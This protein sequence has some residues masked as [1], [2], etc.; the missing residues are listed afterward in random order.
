MR[1]RA[2]SPRRLP[3]ALVLPPG[4][5]AL[6]LSALALS[7]N[8]IQAGPYLQDAT[9]GSLWVCWETAANGANPTESRVDYGTSPLLGQTVHGTY[10]NSS[11]GTVIHQTLVSGLSPDTIY[12]Y[13][14][15]TGSWASGV[16]HFRTQPAHDAE[17]PWR[18]AAMSDT[19]VDGSNPQKHR[20]VIEDGVIDYV[21]SQ[22]GPDVPSE[23]SFLIN[24]GDLVSTGTNHS[25]WQDHFFAQAEQLLREVPLYPVLGN[26]EINADLYFEYMR[27][28]QNGTPG[29]LEHWYYTDHQNVRLIGL[30]TNAPYDNQTQLD[31][32]DAVLAGA[33]LDDRIDFVFVQFHHPHKSELWLPGESAFSGLIVERLEQFSTDTGKP[34]IHFFGHTHGYSRGQSRDHNHLWVNVATGMG[35]PDYWYEYS[36]ADYPEFQI[37]LPE[38]GFAVIDVTAGADPSFRLRR[39]S[40]GNEVVF[41]DNELVDEIT[42]RRYNQPPAQPTAISPNPASGSVPGFGVELVSSTFVDP[43]GDTLLE[44]HWQVTAVSGDYSDPLI[45]DWRR[46]ENWYRPPNGDGWYSVDIVVDPD[47]EDVVLAESLPG[48]Q[49]VWWRVRHRDSGLE[50]S[51]WSEEQTFTVGVSDGGDNIPD[52]ADGA[53]GVALAPVLEWFP[54][55]PADAYDVYFGSTPSLGSGDFQGS[56]A[57][58]TFSPGVLDPEATYYWRI[59]HVNGGQT[60]TG[61]TWSFTTTEVFPTPYTSEWRFADANPATGVPLEAA[62]GPSELVPEGMSY[63]SDWLLGTT[64]ASIPHI[65]GEQTGYL[66]LDEVFGW[67]TG[68]RTWFN[69]P[70]NGGGGGT[71][72]FEFTLIWDLFVPVSESAY[73]AL[74]QGN[75]NNANDAEFFLNNTSGGF[76]MSE[77]GDVGA[78]SWSRGE[79]VRIAHRVDYPDSSAVF[80][81]GVKVLSDDDTPA[82]DWL[83]GEGSGNSVWMLTDQNGGTDVGLVYCANL[84]LTDGLMPDAAIAAL[85]GPDA[86]GIFVPQVPE[87]Y[88]VAAPNSVGAGCRIGWTGS[89]SVGAGDFTLYAWGGI[90][91]QFG[92]FYYGSDQTQVPFG[93]GFR[94]VDGGSLGVFRLN[95]PATFDA[96]GDMTRSLDFTQPPVGSGP[97]S[98]EPGEDWNFQLWYR[99]PVGGGSGFNL[100]D[101]LSV[102]F[103]P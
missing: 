7:G 3:R 68:L 31:W 39:L 75:A 67:Q 58:T 90:P 78:G 29:F 81:N 91:G 66:R 40:R 100:S 22:Y 5:A 16:H 44:S 85:G 25:H 27:T 60:T 13:Q 82:P 72:V 84:A 94:C 86:E 38:W 53:T 43:D 64:G 2:S 4:A 61:P 19:Q 11:A 42:I 32:L 95:P 74:W 41:K 102:P 15:I 30:D 28:P 6:F 77:T 55:E 56:Q 48:C 50:W 88:C 98:I 47:I 33:A 49:P 89:T 37:S 14:V 63:G 45:D 54:C 17:T 9:P 36:Q 52:P 70:G 99:D 57:G 92:L 101:A 83:Y 1:S 23:L 93:E 26:H 69:A 46:I 96:F 51:E 35:N 76:W 34:S 79:W 73:Q 62:F 8:G 59:D 24:C 21:K 80:V 97:G 65:D 18:F 20:E 103:T 71:D 10:L 87:V 12:Y